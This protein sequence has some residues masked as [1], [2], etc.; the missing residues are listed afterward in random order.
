MDIL[1]EDGQKQYSLIYD[2]AAKLR[3]VFIETTMKIKINQP[4]PTL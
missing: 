1:E 2:Y 3:R 4:Q